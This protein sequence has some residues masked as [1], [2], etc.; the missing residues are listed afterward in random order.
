MGKTYNSLT[1]S[2]IKNSKKEGFYNRKQADSVF[3]KYSIG[4]DM[5]KMGE[6]DQILLKR[7]SLQ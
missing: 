2:I 7:T 1:N 6:I 5:G 3:P 4:G